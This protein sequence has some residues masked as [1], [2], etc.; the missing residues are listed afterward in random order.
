MA[1]KASYV[2]VSACPYSA[3]WLAHGDLFRRVRW[4][5][6]STKMEQASL[7][8]MQ[9][10]KDVD[11]FQMSDQ[12]AYYVNHLSEYE[13]SQRKKTHNLTASLV[14]EAAMSGTAA[15]GECSALAWHRSNALSGFLAIMSFYGG[16]PPQVDE[17]HRVRSVG[18]GNS[19]ASRAVKAKQ[20]VATACSLLRYFETVVIAVSSDADFGAISAEVISQCSY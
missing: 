16:I 20:G 13:H 12:D 2:N 11:I 19:L 14:M 1:F 5:L 17:Q 6:N 18:E 3:S 7:M 15:R 10:T 4:R 8:L 9:Q